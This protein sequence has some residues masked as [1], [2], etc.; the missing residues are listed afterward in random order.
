MDMSAFAR[1]LQDQ[2]LAT[3]TVRGYLADLRAFAR[4]FEQTNGEALTPEAV[5]PTDIREYRAWLARRYAAATV[6]R[7]LLAVR[8]WLDW[9]VQAGHVQANPARKV[10]LVREQPSGVR[11]LEK[12]A[13]YAL[14]RAAE[15]ILQVARLRYPRRWVVLERDALLTLFLLNTGLRVGEVV[16]L[17]WGAV[18]LRPRSGHVIVRQGKGGKQRRVPLN[19]EARK[20]LERWKQALAE[21]GLTPEWVWCDAHGRRVTPRSVQR[22]VARVARE[23]GLEGVTPHAL[24]HTFGKT[25]ARVSGIE[26]AAAVLGHKNLDTTR[27]YVE[28]SAQD[29]ARAVNEAVL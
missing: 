17:T 10:R 29:L 22:A 16:T 21:A 12:R 4:W 7:R 3:A 26:F 20:V 9:A 1:H 13:V 8:K 28:P 6:N 23:A 2:D 25:L 5:T 11:W 19:V 24:R 15:R 14:R 18:E 27:R